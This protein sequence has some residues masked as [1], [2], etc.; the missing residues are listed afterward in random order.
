MAVP[1]PPSN[2]QPYIQEAAQG[3]G[4]PVS[5]VQAQA[6]AESGYNT[7]AVSSTGAEGFWQFEPTTYNALAAQAGVPAGSEF[8][9]A[10]ETKVYIQFMNQL[11]QQEGGS[12]FKALEA[13]NAGPGN[14]PAGQGYASGILS[15][16]GVSQNAKF[17]SPSTTAT[18]TGLKIPGIPGNGLPFPFNLL[19]IPGA[20]IPGVSGGGGSS[21]G[22]NI[23]AYLFQGIASALGLPSINDLLQRLGL[24]LLGVILI[25]VG[26]VMLTK[27]SITN[28]AAATPERKVAKLG[29]TE[30]AAVA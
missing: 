19:P 14:L 27:G 7:G 15:S 17:G 24:I 9:V 26:L 12:V 11:N 28:I 30:E 13:Y 29:M 18:T 16:A 25:V 4:L 5:V 6:Y 1:A 22:T 20:G 2:L 21:S 10:D 3:T 23:V 8:N